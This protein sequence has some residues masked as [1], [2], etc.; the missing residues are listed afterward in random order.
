[1]GLAVSTASEPLRAAAWVEGFL[2]GGGEVLHHD[3]ALFGLFDSWLAGLSAESF[4]GLLP[5]LRRTF[6]TFEPPLRRNLGEKAA[7]SKST[8]SGAAAK[9]KSTVD[10]DADRAALVLPLVAKLLGLGGDQAS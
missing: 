10:I 3:D 9:V 5:I 1:M 2:R 4:P 7:Q 8:G 6:S